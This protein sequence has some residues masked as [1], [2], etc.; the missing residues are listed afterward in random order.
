MHFPAP[1]TQTEK[2]QHAGHAASA[3]DDKEEERIAVAALLELGLPLKSLELEEK[4][5][6]GEECH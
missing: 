1:P 3:H 5:M 6:W 4:K 2:G